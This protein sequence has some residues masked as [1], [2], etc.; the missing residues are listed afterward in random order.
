MR[1]KIEKA[2]HVVM[3]RATGEFYAHEVNQDKIRIG[4]LSVLHV[5]SKYIINTIISF[6]VNINEIVS[7]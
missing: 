7:M 5:K 6:P 4:F 2:K 3:F 1:A